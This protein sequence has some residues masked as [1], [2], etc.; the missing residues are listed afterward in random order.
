M[1]TPR[2]SK[3][4]AVPAYPSRAGE[5]LRGLVLW[6]ECLPVDCESGLARAALHGALPDWASNSWTGPACEERKTG[7]GTNEKPERRYRGSDVRRNGGSAHA[8]CGDGSS[9]RIDWSHGGVSGRREADNSY[10]PATESQ[11]RGLIESRSPSAVSSWGGEPFVKGQAWQTDRP[12]VGPPS[13]W[14]H[15]GRSRSEGTHP[16]VRWG[17]RFHQPRDS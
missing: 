12:R 16:P 10:E 9:G 3:R 4:A 13:R 7:G 8:P 2:P 17:C 15:Q 14:S 6:P 11:H 1:W 5:T